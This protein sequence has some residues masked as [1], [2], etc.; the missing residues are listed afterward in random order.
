MALDEVMVEMGI[1]VLTEEKE[2][3]GKRRWNN[4]NR[5]E[6][7]RRYRTREYGRR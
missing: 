6:V 3:P 7:R 5:G 1:K 4:M 2:E